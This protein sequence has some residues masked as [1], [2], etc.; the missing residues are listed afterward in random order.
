MPSLSISPGRPLAVEVGVCAP[1]H[2]SPAGD[3]MEPPLNRNAA[4]AAGPAAPW[5]VERLTRNNPGGI[6]APEPQLKRKCYAV[7]ALKDVLVTRLFK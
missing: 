5:H 4:E 2:V 6:P 3:T 7:A 1:L